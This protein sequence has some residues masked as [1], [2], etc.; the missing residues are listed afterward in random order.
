MLINKSAIIGLKT[1][2]QCT[3]SFVQSCDLL[4]PWIL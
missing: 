3:M 2:I 4:L 1:L